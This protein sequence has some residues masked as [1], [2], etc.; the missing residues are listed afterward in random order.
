MSSFTKI[1]S[2]EADWFQGNRQTDEASHFSQF[3]ERA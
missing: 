1:L 3:C 2:V